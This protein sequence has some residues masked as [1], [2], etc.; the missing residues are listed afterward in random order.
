M[1]TKE[2]CVK[3]WNAHNEIE[4]ANKLLSDMA[5]NLKDDKDKSAPTLRNAFG[6]NQGLQLGVPS[7]HDSHYLY[8]VSSALAVKVIEEHIKFNE[9]RL[10]ELNAI[11]K[12]ELL[13]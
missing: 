8:N 5:K 1:I 3:I 12:I 6:E 2:T 9:I 4:K 10:E 7:G 13:G 11:A